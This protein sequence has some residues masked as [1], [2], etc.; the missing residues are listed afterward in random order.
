[1]ARTGRGRPPAPARWLDT[2]AGRIRFIHYLRGLDGF[3]VP[4]RTGSRDGFIVYFTLHLNG[5]PPRRVTIQF[6][7]ASPSTPLVLVD[8]PTESP[9]RYPDGSLC[10]WFPED[11]SARRWTLRDGSESLVAEIA[12]HLLREEWYRRTGDW[13]GPEVGHHRHSTANEPED[14]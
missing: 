13:V 5:L 12:A 11:P 14:A 3:A 10:M 9:H 7:R 4:H 2:P 1:M 6:R 8:G